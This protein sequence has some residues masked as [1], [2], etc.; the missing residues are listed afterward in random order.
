MQS[1]VKIF[2]K[3]LPIRNRTFKAKGTTPEAQM[4]VGRVNVVTCPQNKFC[5]SQFGQEHSLA[6]RKIYSLGFKKCSFVSQ[7]HQLAMQ[8]GKDLGSQKQA[9][10]CS[11]SIQTSRSWVT[12]GKLA[13]SSKAQLPHLQNRV[14]YRAVE[15]RLDNACEALNTAHWGYCQRKGC[16]QLK[17]KMKRSPPGSPET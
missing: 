15:V 2:F 8:Y 1:F 17:S 9:V 4:W 7:G 11:E 14:Q 3:F 6:F 12:L 13:S 10:S 16:E 5:I